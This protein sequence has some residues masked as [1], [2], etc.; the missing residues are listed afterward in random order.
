MVS[1]WR[2]RSE[3]RQQAFERRAG[4]LSRSEELLML[5]VVREM[6]YRLRALQ[7]FI[8]T[9]IPVSV[10]V[11]IRDS[12]TAFGF[13]FKGVL[14]VFIVWLLYELYEGHRAFYA[15]LALHSL[16]ERSI[17]LRL[18]QS[19]PTLPVPTKTEGG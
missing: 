5:T 16:F 8:L 17:E 6:R 2:R 11:A 14:F 1:W 3:A 12:D 15:A 7:W 13:V 9:L 19:H 4:A 10:A 18:E